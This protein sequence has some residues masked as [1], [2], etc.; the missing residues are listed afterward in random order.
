M[1]S[2]WPIKAKSCTYFENQN[3]SN[4]KSIR[5]N[6]YSVKCHF[7]YAHWFAMEKIRRF[8]IHFT[9]WRPVAMLILEHQ[10]EWAGNWRKESGR[11][12]RN[13]TAQ[14]LERSKGKIW[15]GIEH[16]S[17]AILIRIESAVYFPVTV[18]TFP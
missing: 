18:Y 1:E 16:E 14:I 10:W 12:S 13:Q 4:F 8:N 7:I 3:Q 9:R 6:S 5:S 2:S 17:P 11:E 15:H